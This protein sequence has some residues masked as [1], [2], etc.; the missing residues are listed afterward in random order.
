[1]NS[2]RSS[3]TE[4]VDKHDYII[5]VIANEEARFYKTLDAGLEILRE[6]IDEA[7]DAMDRNAE[8]WPIYFPSDGN[9]KTLISYEEEIE[10]LYVWLT[11]RIEYLTPIFNR[12]ESYE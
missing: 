3:T 4:L 5:S 10:K 11:D 1:M 7:K 6:Y 8:R 2:A 12:Y 9:P